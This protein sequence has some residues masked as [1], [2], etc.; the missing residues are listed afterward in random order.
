VVRRATAEFVGTGLLLFA[1]VGSG[2][3]IEDPSND[4]ALQLFAHAVIV[5]AILALLIALLGPVSGAHL[6]PAVTLAAWRQGDV[7]GRLAGAYVVAQTVGAVAGVVLA[8]A[9]FERAL[10]SISSTVRDGPGR[11]LAEALSTFV[12][13]LLIFGL[14]RTNRPHLIPWTV[15]LWIAGAIFATSSTG[16]ANPA[17]TLAR[18]LTDTFTGIAP[19]NVPAFIL[20]QLI[21]A[22]L[23]AAAIGYL[24]P[25]PTDRLTREETLV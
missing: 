5:G 22:L 2:I 18:S 19:V 1:I 20:S 10:V 23:A 12:L 14:T 8:H 7:T 17:V 3:V 6:N 21:G 4:P 16:F 15:G 9:T 11:A 25:T 24:F 13:V